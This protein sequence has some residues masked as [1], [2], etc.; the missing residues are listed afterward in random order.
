MIGDVIYNLL[1]S[2]GTVSGLVGTKIYGYI[3]KRNIAYPYIIYEIDD[4]DPTNTKDGVSELD[5]CFYDI[6]CYAKNVSD[7]T[8]LKL[9]IRNA[10]DR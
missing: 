1:S 5:E 3:A 2:D 10:I 9:A 6:E 4:V 8:A 7:I